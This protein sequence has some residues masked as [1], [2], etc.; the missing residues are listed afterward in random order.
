VRTAQAFYG[1][2]THL[3]RI[4][5]EEPPQPLVMLPAAEWLVHVRPPGLA[6]FVRARRAVRMDPLMALRHE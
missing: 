5:L 6:A 2:L 4:R 1:P 3:V